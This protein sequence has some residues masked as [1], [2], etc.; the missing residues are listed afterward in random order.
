LTTVVVGGGIAGL[1]AARVLARR[2]EDVRLLEASDRVGGVIRS[3][4]T[5]DGFLLELGPNTVRPTPEL[6]A[7]VHELG[8]EGEM[9]LSDPR[10]PRWL[11]WR[12]RLHALPA[13]PGAFLATPLLSPG[14]KLRVLA[15]P[16]VRRRAG[17][18]TEESLRTFFTRRV[19]RQIADRFVDP[20]VSGIFA[21]D[22][23]RL[24]VEAAFPALAR[25]EREHGSLFRWG[26]H[27]R[28]QRPRPR[29]EAPKVRGLL[30]F[31]GGL[32]TLP[33]AIA[34]ELGSRVETTTPVRSV[35][36]SDSGWTLDTTKGTVSASRLIL[37][38]PSAAAARLVAPFAPE[39]ASA[40]TAIPAPPVSVLHLAF[41][42]SALPAPLRGFGHLVVRTPGR[43]ILGAVW[44]SSLFPGRA[45][46]GTE[47]VTAFAGGRRD[48]EAARLG[49]SELTALA[50][51]EL[52]YLLGANED[53]SLVRRTT[54]DA[55]IP[56]YEIGHGARIATLE[57]A[58]SRWQRLT[59]VGAYRGGISVGDVV[60]SAAAA[61]APAGAADTVPI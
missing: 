11:A 47:L 42:R 22:P 53:P 24:A 16:F 56:Q 12:G 57:R 19:G 30:S 39:A 60:R 43:R 9:L 54:W 29:P 38:C 3:E 59:F 10:A 33:R 7:L 6:L 23:D 58:E 50:A 25:G 4:R 31:R 14:G 52:R 21:G 13:S 18:A 34:A 2:G 32:E 40:L 26:L 51:R 36:P 8:L 37:A 1:V 49:D 48:P 44:S 20:F 55:A 5:E 35:A 45:P 46:E 27:A 61:A 28:R 17:D 41:P 15:E